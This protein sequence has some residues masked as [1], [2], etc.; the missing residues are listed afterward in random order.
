MDNSLIIEA[1]DYVRRLFEER[2]S[3]AYFYH[4]IN[5]TIEVVEGCVEL[6]NSF[7]IDS[8]ESEAL[9]I[10]AWFHDT[11]YIYNHEGHEEQ[12]EILAEEFLRNRNYPE[13]RLK[14]VIDCIKSTKLPQS[15]ETL[16]EKIL[17]DAEFIYLGKDNFFN[18]IE[19]LRKE[20]ELSQ[21]RFYDEKEWLKIN[22]DFFDEHPF[23]TKA[24]IEKY[25]KK[26]REN[27][28]L[29]ISMYKKAVDS[30]KTGS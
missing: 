2:L 28:L 8:E 27:Y 22:I 24:A 3:N 17:C 6:S 30:Y 7:E 19:L 23:H 16:I 20:W 5:H 10:A 1:S 12:S 11:G 25:G 18:K 15:P 26:R 29:L 21:Q 13:D 14:V 9:L 4:D